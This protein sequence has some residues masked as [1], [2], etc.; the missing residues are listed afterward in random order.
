MCLRPPGETSSTQAG[1]TLAAPVFRS[2]CR[3]HTRQVLQL[4]QPD[5]VTRQELGAPPSQSA[6]GVLAHQGQA[7]SVGEGEDAPS[8]AH[9]SPGGQRLTGARRRRRA[10]CLG[11]R[12]GLDGAGA[13]RQGQQHRGRIR[14]APSP[15][16]LA[17][18][19]TPA[20]APMRPFGVSGTARSAPLQEGDQAHDRHGEHRRDHDH[21]HSPSV[22]GHDR[23]RH[24][25]GHDQC[26]DQRSHHRPGH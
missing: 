24:R 23:D 16:R 6:L 13:S 5:L 22:P 25:A 3:R 19:V 1:H 20:T 2:V 21:A 12:S 18:A 14:A 15:S 10:V 8:S 7:L 11:G 26:A 9:A 4:A 17:P